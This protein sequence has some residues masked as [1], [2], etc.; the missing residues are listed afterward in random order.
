M[1]KKDLLLIVAI[2]AIVYFYA[3]Y[4]QAQRTTT[5]TAL[6]GGGSAAAADAI[7]ANQ[8]GIPG[9]NPPSQIDQILGVS[10]GSDGIAG[11]FPLGDS[12]YG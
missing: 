4:K 8:N 5:A 11:N 3:K 7:A 1:D 12:I 2:I 10:M 6:A 9:F